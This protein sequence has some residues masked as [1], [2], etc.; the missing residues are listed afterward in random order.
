M[1][2]F[3]VTSIADTTYGLAVDIAAE[4]TSKVAQLY[5]RLACFVRTTLQLT[6]AACTP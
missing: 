2:K 4:I 5:G 6:S 3:G 1:C